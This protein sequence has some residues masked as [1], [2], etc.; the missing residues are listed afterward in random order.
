MF[1]SET[2][3]V[4]W[5]QRLDKRRLRALSVGIGD[6]AAVAEVL[7]GH[8]LLLT[9][10]LSIAGVHFF[11]S[12]HPPRTVGHRALARSLSD[13]AAMGGVPRFA[14]VSLAVSRSTTRAWVSAFFAGLTSLARRFNVKV[15][16]GDTA[17]V[18]GGSVVD[19]VVVGEIPRG[20]AVLRS[21]A[22]P[23]DWIFV[24]G[25]L[26]L[27]A[28]GLRLLKTRGVSPS[29]GPASRALRAHLYPEPRCALGLFLSKNRLASAL[30]DVSDGLS[31]D[32]S[33]L[34]E[35]SGVGAR[36]RADRVPGPGPVPTGSDRRSRAA[37]RTSFEKPDDLFDLALHG[38]EDYEL[39]FTVPEAKASRIPRQ[40]RG[41]PLHH[42]GKIT[43]S[44]K[45][46]LIGRNGVE[47]TLKPG[48]YD[49]FRNG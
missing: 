48:G 45:M 20:G 28:L 46:V 6:D 42:I 3:F 5:L 22:R 34:C 15:V 12:F 4:Q 16:G 33:H 19:V 23:G 10:D 25:R 32:L 26:G 29:R 9:T 21:G 27:S 11:P 13:I 35:A 17:L 2:E 1:R 37:G 40:Y 44:G 30:I 7:R 41:I 39:L 14:L 31:T 43:S 24:S 38:G 8:Q 36:L 47:R 49:H 18:H